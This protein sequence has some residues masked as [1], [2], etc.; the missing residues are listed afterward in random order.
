MKLAVHEEYLQSFRSMYLTIGDLQYKKERNMEE[1]DKKIQTAHIQQ[2]SPATPCFGDPTPRPRGPSNLFYIYIEP[3]APSRT[4][5]PNHRE[6]LKKKNRPFLTSFTPLFSD[7]FQLCHTL[8][9]WQ[10][11][12]CSRADV[13][14]CIP[15]PS[16]SN[17]LR[18]SKGW[19]TH[20]P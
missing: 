10:V 7:V 15:T 4:A 3:A 18:A 8:K 17:S 16:C 13:F 20:D 19:T 11:W 5:N 6:N 1:L 9:Q 14:P 12:S 2:V